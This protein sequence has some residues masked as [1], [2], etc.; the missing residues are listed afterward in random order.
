MKMRFLCKIGIHSW[1]NGWLP[2][3]DVHGQ[4]CKLCPKQRIYTSQ[5]QCSGGYV[6]LDW[7]GEPMDLQ[8]TLYS[9][10]NGYCDP[11]FDLT[12]HEQ[13]RQAK[14]IQLTREFWFDIMSFFG[15]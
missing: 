8:P 7:T 3:S 12:A 11:N 15:Q 6:P 9:G 13:K 4:K 14:M 5:H 1:E 10:P 2:Q